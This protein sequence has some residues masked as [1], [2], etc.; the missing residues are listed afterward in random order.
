MRNEWTRRK[1]GE[2]CQLISGT[3]ISHEL[4]QPIGE[5]PY[6]KVGDMNL[7]GNE[8]Y[9]TTS[10]RY[11][12]QS[13]IRTSQILPTGAVIFPKRGGAIATNKKRKLIG[14]TIVDLN[15]M[16]L[17]PHEVLDN[18][19]LYYWLLQIDLASIANGTSIPQINNY[20]FDN[21][22]ISFPTVTEQQNIV[23]ILDEAFAAIDQA[24]ANVQKNINN[25]NEL[26][27]TELNAIFSK[28]GNL[29][30]RKLSDICE[31]T[32]FLVD[33]KES[34]Y[35]NLT[36]VGAGNIESETGVLVGLM[37]AKEENLISGKF[38]FDET[39]VLYSKI[40]PY[41]KKVVNC[42]FSGLCS[43]DI[44]P[45]SPIDGMITKDFLY[46]L[47]LCEDFTNY[48]IEGS[49]RAGMPK[50]NRE[51]LF[52]YRFCLPA[53]SAQIDIVKKLKVLQKRVYSLELSYT[54]KLAHLESLKK[55]I[56][57]KAIVG[58]LTESLV[59]QETFQ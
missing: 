7:P 40:R 33:P 51:H 23:S 54:T 27:Q 10:S 25:T 39:M 37:T 28:K 26:F 31:I 24:K 13:S 6:I 8:E 11:V 5:I 50:V 29:E 21:I 47:L 56:L 41:L 59:T 16:A 9:I 58:E 18:N 1:I 30:E 12:N 19:F 38:L 15:I 3:T 22:F 43:A 48:A 36:H 46:Y 4:E 55:S 20:S 52:Q 34:Q 32:S 44:Y 42:N 53:V 35:Q 57:Q 14:P 49:Q 17:V 2:V 45:L